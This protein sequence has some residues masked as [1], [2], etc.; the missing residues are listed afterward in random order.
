[1][2]TVAQLTAIESTPCDNA[3]AF[4]ALAITLA[5]GHVL[6]LRVEPVPGLASLALALT[7]AADELDDLAELVE[8]F[9]LAEAS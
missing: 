2:P 5:G 4:T 3:S 1:M 8:D 7:D 6:V 9:L